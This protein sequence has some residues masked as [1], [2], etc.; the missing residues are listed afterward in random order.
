MNPGTYIGMDTIVDIIIR[1]V[2]IWSQMFLWL[3]FFLDIILR[4][5]II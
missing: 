1:Y 2:C 5:I 3:L 4:K